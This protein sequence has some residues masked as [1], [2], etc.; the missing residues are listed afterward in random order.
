VTFDDGYQNVIENALPEWE[1]R[2]IPSTLFII[3]EALGKPAHWLTGPRGPDWYGPVMTADQ[4]KNLSAD[5]VAIG[6][7]TATHPLLPALSAEE[8]MRE[9]SQSRAQLERMLNRKVGLFSFPYGAHHARLIECCREAGYDRVF[10]TRPAL[11]F[12]D[13][14]EF[15]TGRVPVEPSDWPLE[16]RLKLSGAYRWMPAAFSLKRKLQGA[17]HR[18]GGS[19]RSSVHDCSPSTPSGVR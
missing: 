4:M 7:H 19:A 10:T 14:A 8:A 5:L 11:A 15:T 1:K 12:A 18:G 2:A 6:S 17:F 9:L 16:F 13:P 3:T